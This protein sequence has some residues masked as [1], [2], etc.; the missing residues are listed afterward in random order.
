MF[1]IQIIFKYHSNLL[2]YNAILE[3]IFEQRNQSDCRILE[4]SIAQQFR[5]FREVTT[6]EQQLQLRVDD[7]F[8]TATW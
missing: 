4:K 6:M 2:F 5:F 3:F 1:I 8:S 7:S